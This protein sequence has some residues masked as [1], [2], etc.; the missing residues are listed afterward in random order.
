MDSIMEEACEEASTKSTV[1]SYA[2]RGSSNYNCPK[3]VSVSY[4]KT[5]NTTYTQTH[6]HDD[7]R[8]FD[9]SL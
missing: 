5:H 4:R 3:L 9:I 6:T 7:C 2:E 8:H 1:V